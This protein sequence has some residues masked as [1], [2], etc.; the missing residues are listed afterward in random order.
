MSTAKRQI[1]TPSNFFRRVLCKG[2]AWMEA[3]VPHDPNDGESEWS[4]EGTMLH[5]VMASLRKG[6]GFPAG[7]Y[8]DEQVEICHRANLLVDKAIA[9]A[10]RN[11]GIPSDSAF[12]DHYE[13]SLTM[14]G[15][16]GEELYP[17]TCD[18]IRVWP[19][20]GVAVVADYKF[21][22]VEVDSADNNWQL[23][24]YYVMA[25]DRFEASTVFPAI[26]QPRLTFEQR[27]TMTVYDAS[28][29]ESVRAEITR[30]YA[31]S[32]TQGAPIN[33]SVS[34]CRNC[35]ARLLCEAS[36]GKPLAVQST[37]PANLLSLP[38]DKFA[39]VGDAIKFA[40]M[41][42]RDWTAEALRRIDAG[43]L[44]GWKRK[45]NGAVTELTDAKEAFSRFLSRYPE[46]ESL[47]DRFIA[48]GDFSIV[49][50]AKLTKELTGLSE[51]KARKEAEEILD[52]LLT[53]TAKADSPVRAK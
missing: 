1:T 32:M 33:P 44:P 43:E 19:E 48:C 35:R 5:E 45:S 47:A 8:T 51:K 4:K 15:S 24:N 50:I 34:A 16:G 14:T 26:I 20:H 7:E 40:D 28:V 2:S 53:K 37:E 27:L 30:H 21:G 6:E 18:F 39:A 13:L 41:I 29:L 10:I 42:K 17:G 22:R 11:A 49:E 12:E 52:G 46:A 23:A 3:R 25:S 31:E 36:W 38:A 9:D